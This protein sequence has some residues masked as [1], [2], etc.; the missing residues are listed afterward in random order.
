MPSWILCSPKPLPPALSKVRTWTAIRSASS[1]LNLMGRETV[2]TVGNAGAAALIADVRQNWNRPLSHE[3]L[4][5]WQSMVI[6]EQFTSR[7]TRG[8]YRNSPEPMQIISGRSVVHYEAPPADQVPA[9][10]QRFLDWYNSGSPVTGS[11]EVLPG[12]V[13][14]AVAHIMVRAYPSLR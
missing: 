12:P 11:G 8:A 1:L 10:M 7:V 3:I 6:V 2:G 4:G 5:R 13:R 14:A 9:E